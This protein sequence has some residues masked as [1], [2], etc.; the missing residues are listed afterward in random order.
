MHV[1]STMSCQICYRDNTTTNRLFM[2][3]TLHMK[4][5]LVYMSLVT[6]VVTFTID[7]RVTRHKYEWVTRHKYEWVTRHKYEWVTRLE[8]EWVTCHKYE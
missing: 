7:E 2:A 5:Y 6:P 8:H 3:G 1:S 4:P